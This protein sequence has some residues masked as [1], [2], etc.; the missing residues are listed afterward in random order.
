MAVSLRRP[1]FRWVVLIVLIGAGVGVAGCSESTEPSEFSGRAPL[2]LCGTVDSRDGVD[3]DEQTAIT[4]LLDAHARGETGEL[5]VR[6]NTTEGEAVVRYVRALTGGSGE[7]FYDARRDSYAS[8]DWT[9]QGDCRE[10]RSAP[11]ELL[12]IRDC[13]GVVEIG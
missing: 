5:I 2:S 10:I 1:A 13:S 11:I 12:A 9:Y 4:C 6:E 8:T 7:V 3:A